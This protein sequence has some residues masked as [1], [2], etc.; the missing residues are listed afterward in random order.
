MEETGIE[1]NSL[2]E[3]NKLAAV[4]ILVFA[5]KQDLV[6]AMPADEI[7]TALSLHGIRD[8]HWQIQPCSAKTGEGIQNGMEWA[9]KSC[10]NK[11]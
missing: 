8:R 9:T 3:E 6:H 5:N 7:A 1:L 11:R 10:G 2:M 4:P